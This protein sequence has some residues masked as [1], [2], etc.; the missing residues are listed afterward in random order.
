M[1]LRYFSLPP[2]EL[3]RDVDATYVGDHATYTS[4]NYLGGSPV[5]RIKLAHFESALRLTREY[6]GKTNAIDFGCADGVLIPSL[7]GHYPRVLGI[8]VRPEWAALTER[9]VDALGLSNA[10]VICNAGLDF[11]ELAEITRPQGYQVAYLLE[12]LEHIGRVEAMYESRMDFLDEL[13]TLLTDD[14]VVVISVPTM[15]G[16]AFLLQR[17]ALS[18]LRKQREP[19]SV[20]DL[21]AAG[22]FS[23]TERLEPEWYGDHLGFNHRK[24]ERHLHRRF[25][26][27][28]KRN[29]F[30]TQV[31]LVGRDKAR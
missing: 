27:L 1:P 16:P 6:F 25:R 30:F 26:V 4:Y 20:P 2:S 3:F 14:G 23:R 29:L 19:I 24:L 13:F 12:T 21:L 22:L 18:T 8:E 15:V 28:K 31:Y 9:V 10:S 11:S 7:A 17:L 5:A